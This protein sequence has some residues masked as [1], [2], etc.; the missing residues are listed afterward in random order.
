MSFEIFQ[1][2]IMEVAARS[3]DPDHKHVGTTVRKL[4]RQ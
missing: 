3:S 4:E 1:G 2:R